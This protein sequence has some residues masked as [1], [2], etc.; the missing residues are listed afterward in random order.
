MPSLPSK[1]SGSKLDSKDPTDEHLAIEEA[2]VMGN[3]PVREARV[4][5]LHISEQ[6]RFLSQLKHLEILHSPQ[7]ET[8]VSQL[9]TVKG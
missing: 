5:S 8:G 1:P 9:N 3:V 2:Q 6:E 4:P 7:L